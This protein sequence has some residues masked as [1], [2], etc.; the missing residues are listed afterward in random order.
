MAGK[1]HR[2]FYPVR[3]ASY[4]DKRG[5]I[6]QNREVSLQLPRVPTLSVLAFDCG[7]V[8]WALV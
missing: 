1:H 2:A 4:V 5:Q 6:S 7:P 8:A 3:P